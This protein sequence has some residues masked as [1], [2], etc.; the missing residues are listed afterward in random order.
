MRSSTEAAKLIAAWAENNEKL[1]RWLETRGAS[2]ETPLT[3]SKGGILLMRDFFPCAIADAVLA[4]LEA[5]PEDA[6]ELSKQGRDKGAAHHSFWSADICDIPA[7]APLRAVFWRMLRSFRGE[8]TLPIFSIGRYG[9]SDYIGR[10]DDRAFVPMLSAGNVFSR[11]VAGIWYLTRDWGVEEGGCLRD[12]EAEKA[13]ASGAT[14]DLVPIFNSLALFEVPHW[15]AVTAVTAERYR[16]SIFGWWHQ[17]GQ[18]YELPGCEGRERESPVS[19]KKPK[20]KRMKVPT[21]LVE[22]S[23]GGVPLP[24]RKMPKKK[25]RKAVTKA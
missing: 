1:D 19:T 8:P 14:S 23:P 7:L 10:H 17:K 18:R 6:W 4:I 20:K 15:H 24:G 5:L 22:H 2:L 12:L 11:T 13:A 25:I 3:E 21:E 9:A 16:Y